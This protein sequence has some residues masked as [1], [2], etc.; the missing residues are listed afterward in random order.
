MD[1]R[2]IPGM[3]MLTLWTD[4]AM[5]VGEHRIRYKFYYSD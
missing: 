4:M 1:Q 2:W 3:Y 5:E